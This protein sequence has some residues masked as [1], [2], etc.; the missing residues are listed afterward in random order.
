MDNTNKPKGTTNKSP[1]PKQAQ[2]HQETGHP[3]ANDDKTGDFTLATNAIKDA[4]DKTNGQRV[5]TSSHEVKV[6]DKTSVKK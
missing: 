1:L 6:D 3:L 4:D 2:E 5:P